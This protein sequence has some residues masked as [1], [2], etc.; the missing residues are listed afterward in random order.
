M[1]TIEEDYIDHAA[2]S[3]PRAPGV[4]EAMATALN[5][6][7][8]GRGGHRKSQTA[9]DL[10]RCVREKAAAYF[11]LADAD[12][13]IFTSGA[14]MSLNIAIRGMLRPG[15][16]VVTTCFEHNSVLRPLRELEKQGCR[17]SII[18]RAVI[19]SAI[20]DL[21]H[22]E[23][24]P[25]TR[26]VVLSLASNVLG[27]VLPVADVLAIAHRNGI[28][29]LV[30]AAQGT[31]H[32]HLNLRE[33]PIDIVA[34]GVHKGLLGPPG[35]GLL[36]LNNP[37]ITVSPIILGGT[38]HHSDQLDPVY[39]L[40]HSLEVGT[41]NL[42]AIAGLGAALDYAKTDECERLQRNSVALRNECWANLRLIDRV[43]LYADASER[44]VPLFS[45]TI[46][47]MFPAQVADILD[48]S[49]NLQLRHGLHCAPLVHDALGT[50]P[51]GTLRV[52]FGPGN[53]RETVTRLVSAISE[54]T[55]KVGIH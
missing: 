52:G 17:V 54:L 1:A 42:P 38:G 27:G 37:T 15:D 53:T 30:D 40:P 41:L 34:T 36:I 5:L 31:G 25:T 55:S 7:N 26:L 14:T 4:V 12:R 45:F 49:H 35:V 33:L 16:H 29:V 8:P 13:L 23:L 28:P 6:G 3:F 2:T 48:E 22:R 39:V 46:D 21:I 10:L 44:S 9:N 50:M 47:G 32:V 20:A 51:H 19:D 43:R 18:K 11:G 24:R